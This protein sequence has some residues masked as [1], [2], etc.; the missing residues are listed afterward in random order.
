MPYRCVETHLEPRGK[1]S[2][3]SSRC[4]FL[5]CFT[6]VVIFWYEYLSVVF[7]HKLEPLCRYLVHVKAVWVPLLMPKRSLHFRTES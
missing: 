1:Y 7:A 3:E 6:V 5:F 2:E 4:G